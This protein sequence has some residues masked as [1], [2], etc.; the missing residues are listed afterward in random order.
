[1]IARRFAVLVPAVVAGSVLILT[2]RAQEAP[3]LFD[4][5]TAR[6]G[7]TFVHQSA[8]TPDKYMM[9]TFG[10]G[11][12]WIDIDNDGFQDLFFVN[13]APGAS[14]VLYRNNRN[15]TFSNVTAQS[16]TAGTS[17]KA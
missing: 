6:A 9:E 12:A 4:D 13:G 8:A 2:G 15:G 17:T 7:I 1:M 10:S 3:V 14:N 11:G 16:G 5:V